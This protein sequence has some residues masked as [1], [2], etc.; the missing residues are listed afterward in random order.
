M[1]YSD[2]SESGFVFSEEV[3][4]VINQTET[5]GFSSS[6][7]CVE[8]KQNHIFLVASL[9]LGEESPQ[10]FFRNVG[11]FWVIDVDNL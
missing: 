10:L 5:S 1:C 6:E 4:V 2:L 7:L 11:E 3:Q 8:S 9:R